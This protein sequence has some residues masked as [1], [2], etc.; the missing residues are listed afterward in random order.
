MSKKWANPKLK[1]RTG[2][3]NLALPVALGRKTGRLIGGQCYHD[4]VYR[5][6]R[7]IPDLNIEYK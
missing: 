2:G 4:V 7:R 5:A 1:K 3:T 6:H